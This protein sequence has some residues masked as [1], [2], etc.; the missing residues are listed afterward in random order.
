MASAGL[1]VVDVESLRL[2]YA[3]TLALYDAYAKQGDN[4]QGRKFATEALPYIADEHAHSATI[5]ARIGG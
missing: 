4:A 2:H 3:R 1:E 5:A